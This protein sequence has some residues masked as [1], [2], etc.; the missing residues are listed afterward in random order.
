MIKVEI[1]TLYLQII[2][3]IANCVIKYI[4]FCATDAHIIKNFC[5]TPCSLVVIE[6]F[7]QNDLSHF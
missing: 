2:N 5:C 6:I 7:Y 1:I 4:L 3:K